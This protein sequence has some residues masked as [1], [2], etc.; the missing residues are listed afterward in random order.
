MR[1]IAPLAVAIACSACAPQQQLLKHTPSG[2]PEATIAARTV[3]EVRA[4]LME[5]CIQVGALVQESAGNN[6]LCSKTMT[7]GDAVLASLL[8]GNSY[9][10]PPE[11]KIRFTVFQLQG[12]VRVTA[13]QWI[14]TQMALGQIRRMELNGNNH[15][16]SVQAMLDR[17]GP[18]HDSEPSPAPVIAPSA[19]TTPAATP[20]GD[21]R[22][23][24]TTASD[25]P[26]GQESSQIDR[27]AQVKLCHPQPRAVVI[28]K[29]PGYE[30]YL[31]ACSNGDQMIFRCEFGNCRVLK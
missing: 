22:L 29:G 7:G 4:S 14:E 20:V 3:D 13:Q 12:N 16:N 30:N 31:V 23:V 28:A 9:S 25:R 27:M 24:T 19:P 18:A 11:Q 6:V 15:R 1:A 5:A 26:I 10:T 21:G 2:Y 8:V 17:L